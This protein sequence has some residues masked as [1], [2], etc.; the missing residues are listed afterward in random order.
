MVEQQVQ[1][2][3]KLQEEA[4]DNL[5]EQAAAGIETPEG[6]PPAD[7]P[8]L[9]P[10]DMVPATVVG[11]Q[12]RRRQAAELENAELKGKLSVLE[13]TRT[14]Q[15][16]TKSPLE[17]YVEQY[18]GE[19]QP[20]AATLLAQEKWKDQQAQIKADA[21]R[22]E[23]EQAIVLENRRKMQTDAAVNF[24]AEKVGAGLD[25]DS[26]TV[27]GQHYLTQ[28]DVDDARRAGPELGA[29]HIYKQ[30]INRTLDAGGAEAKVLQQRLDAHKAKLKQDTLVEQP[31]PDET[32]KSGNLPPKRSKETDAPVVNDPHISNVFGLI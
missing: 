25:F 18:G 4:I 20:D 3:E 14:A 22:Q 1:A 21:V 26:I 5:A 8:V 9:P 29:K 2:E 27:L 16:A 32:E 15:V 24:T 10:E 13:A 6:T 28:G 31:K 11:E 17:S 30:M 19:I 23:R 7:K 12:R